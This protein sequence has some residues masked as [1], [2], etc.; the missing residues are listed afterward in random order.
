MKKTFT[1]L[2][3]A[4][5]AILMMAQPIKVMGQTTVTQTSFSTIS[6]NVNND[7]KVS[8][9]AYKG[10]GTS[11]PAINSSAIRLY[12]NSNGA[13]G[14][15]VVIG[16]DEGYEIT[17]A[18]IQS[19]MATTTGYKLTESDPGST[20][21]A[22]NTFNVS[23][24]SLSA[25]TDYTVGSLSTRYIVFACFGTSSSSRLYL[26]K[27]SITYK[28]SGG[29]GTEYSVTINSMTNGTVQTNHETASEGTT[30]TLTPQP[31]ENYALGSMNV[32]G[33]SSTSYT[34]TDNQNGTWSFEMPAEDVY[35]GATFIPASEVTINVPQDFNN[36]INQSI[37]GG[38]ITATVTD[39]TTST[40]I[41][42]A[43]VT[44]ASSDT[45]VATI[46][47][48]NGNI[49][50][51]LVGVGTTT[52]TA[53]YGGNSS[54][55][56]AEGT[57]ELTVING[58][59]VT[60]DFTSVNNFWTNASHTTHPTIGSSNDHT[61]LTTFYYDNATYDEFTALSGTN[62][63]YYFS[64]NPTYLMMGKMGA[65]LTLPT[66][67]G[68]KIIQL[69]IHNS[70]GCSQSVSVSIVSG[71]NTA[72]NAVTWTQRD[73]DYT[74]NIAS[75]YQTTA[76]S[77]KIANDYNAQITGITVVREDINSNKVATPTINPTGGVITESTSVTISCDTDGAT[78]HYTTDG[79]TPTTSSATY[80]QAITVNSTMTIKAMAVKSGMNNSN[81]AEATFTRK[82]I[83]NLTQLPGGTISANPTQAEVG[84][85]VTLT[86]TPNVGYGFDTW[87][88]T[89][90]T[91]TISENSF[92]MPAEDVTVSATFTASSTS[93]TISFNINDKV[94]MTAT[95]YGGSIDLTKFVA[96][97]T[98]DDYI[99]AG[100]SITSGGSAIADQTSYTPSG[101]V[102][103]YPVFNTPS[104]DDYA[105]VTSTDQLVAGNLVVI[106]ASAY[107][108]AMSTEQKSNNRGEHDITKSG[109]TISWT[110]GENYTVCEFVLGG[111][112]TGWSFYDETNSGYIYAAGTA[113]SGKNYLKTEATLDENS[114][115]LWTI[116]IGS[117]T[118]YKATIKS[119]GNTNTPYL[120]Y[121]T[122]GMFS[123]Y[124]TNS[125]SDVV[126]YTK[127]APSSK[128]TRETITATSNIS[129]IA[130]GVKVTVKNGG[131]V[132]L[133]GSNYGN[134]AN[135]IVENGGQL[136]TSA[137]V[138]GTVQKSVTGYGSATAPSNYYFISTPLNASTNP[139]NVEHMINTAGYDLYYFNQEAEL[140]W[141]N[142]K[143][144]GE[145]GFNLYV[146]SGYLYANRESL[147]LS[148]AGTL[149]NSNTNYSKNL[150]YSNSNPD[151]NMHGWNLIGNPFSANAS[152]PSDRDY[153][154][155]KSDGTEIVAG[156]THIVAPMEGVF[157][158]A[159]SADPVESVTF[160]VSGNAK[161]SSN[162]R[163]I[164]NIVDNN[165]NV[166]D[167]AIVN[168]NEG[169]T[170]PK[171][172]INENNTK[173]YIPQEDD[174]Y[175][176]VLS[177]GQGTM[178]VNFKA[179]EMGMYTISVETE[180]IDLSYLHLIDR[181]TGED[182]NLLMD[183]KYSFIA[184]NS[185][186]ES[187]FILSFDENG[188]NANNNETFAFQNGSEI[189]VNG[190]GELQI[191][192]VMGRNIMNTM[193]N[194]V[195]TVNVKSQG[196]YIFKLNEKTQKIIVR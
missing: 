142:Y 156:T 22:K 16:V 103:L 184:S 116:S 181:L 21:P 151:E 37:V 25:N 52:I 34:L 174:N 182:V 194:G 20:T 126:L 169:G 168:L 179:K 96:N 95:I 87:S 162:S 185:D 102:I 84:A 38:T 186:M 29:G 141:R 133:T 178:P 176:V 120:K 66:Y 7:T 131:I 76:L 104:A 97:P 39:V 149:R 106:A 73:T 79:S 175:A 40:V 144:A 166:I 31:N 112:S 165:S 118:T 98:T 88:V 8:Y 123:C 163:V 193:I 6:G 161:R 177:N 187:R 2:I 71:S 107:G 69:I 180:G 12:Q 105:L 152:I 143:A 51:T 192:D 62:L 3:A 191:F 115:G 24:Y 167:R 99:F 85:T 75:A 30:V 128:A 190:E 27:I 70:S 54:H 10:G 89:P 150:T 41:S 58:A 124:N 53:A 146:G 83:V 32:I 65:S 172:M 110:A 155:M 86:A 77:V 127:P 68:Y 78:I 14:G 81:I 139:M 33:E 72:S 157:V 125:Q 59:Y 117:G 60:Y 159:T 183:S 160:T 44:W 164:L 195:Q 114:W 26:S 93:S 122:Q 101:D 140:E 64:G 91:V 132:Y 153:Y 35:V 9:A 4:I 74:Y 23:N 5:A 19:T 138:K 158:H 42:G 147:T 189:I 57:Y 121:N 171:F 47:N 17:S 108:E 111:S 45:D 148:F 130:A 170:L 15:Y 13:T 61:N 94:E 36:D 135:L 92:T 46:S 196:V 188:I 56:A 119:V 109:T 49:V 173:V 80:S 48:D 82:Y 67:E 11:N 134:E 129:S 136:I 154:V 1:I 90:A 113:A 63:N 50:V 100:W 18:T 145:Q 137:A 55:A 28:E 43:E